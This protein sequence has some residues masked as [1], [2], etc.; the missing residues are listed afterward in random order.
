M[1]LGP[2]AAEQ[3]QPR[4]ASARNSAEETQGA[5]AAARDRPPKVNWSSRVGAAWALEASFGQLQKRI[6]PG[7]TGR[8]SLSGEI[9]T[10]SGMPAVRREVRGGDRL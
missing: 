9:R 1:S 7:L 4:A 5:A 10:A 6:I 3:C 2:A 8:I